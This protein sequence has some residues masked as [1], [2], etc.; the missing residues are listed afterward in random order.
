M[1]TTL[2]ID[3]DVLEAAKK[4]AASRRCP[5]GKVVS[6]LARAGLDDQAPSDDAVATPAATKDESAEQARLAREREELG[7]REAQLGPEY[8]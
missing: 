2:K 3:D 8:D 6:E 7:E 1:R 5:T 4:I